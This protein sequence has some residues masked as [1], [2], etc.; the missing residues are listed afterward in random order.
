MILLKFYRRCTPDFAIIYRHC[1]FN[2]LDCL[3]YSIEYHDC[4]L[5]HKYVIGP[6]KCPILLTASMMQCKTGR[7]RSVLRVQS[8]W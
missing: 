7:I 4:R 8:L 3:E 6:Q 5:P 2:M 1:S